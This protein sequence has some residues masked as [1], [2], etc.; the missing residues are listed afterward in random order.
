MLL[1]LFRFVDPMSQNFAVKLSRI[2]AGTL[3]DNIY[4][5]FIVIFHV[6]QR[7]SINVGLIT[8]V[9]LKSGQLSLGKSAVLVRCLA[10]WCK[11]AWLAGA[12]L[13]G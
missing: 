10:G 4:N 6:P 12:M 13:P 3:L 9:E 8:N 7:V 1:F 11:T 2:D 5:P